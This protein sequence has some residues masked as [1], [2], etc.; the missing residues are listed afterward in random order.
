MM[1]LGLMKAFFDTVD[2][3]W[4]SPLADQIGA[5][6]LGP[7][8]RIRL[9]RA[10]ANFVCM[11]DPPAPRYYL[12]FN[13][14]SERGPGEIAA[15]LTFIEHL[16]RQGIRTARPQP[17]RAGR[18]VESVVTEQGVFHGVLFEALPGAELAFEK[19]DLA[20]FERWGRALGELHRA[21]QGCPMEILKDRPGWQERLA[22]ARREIPAAESLAW[23]ELDTVERALRRLPQDADTYGMIHYDFEQDNLIWD[24][25]APG[26][27]DF[28]DCGP[29]WYAA[30]VAYALRDLFADSSARIDL[31]DARLRAFVSGYRTARPL[32][33]EALGDLPLFLR[34]H[35]LA[36]FARISRSIAGEPLAEEPTWLS[37]L[38]GK[39]AG[40]LEGYRED[41]AQHPYLP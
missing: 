9:W 11:V 12:R 34:L 41:F 3:N 5:R 2:T 28:D 38:R 29:Y 25:S 35:N 32:A 7:E 17:S 22:L 20:G 37:G 40:I 14:E 23:R 15:E 6:W 19:L 10:S 26:V 21:A 4:R 16:A 31:Q 8:A 13:H 24:G 30:D 18:L 33:E 39:L 1:R 36:A 27:L